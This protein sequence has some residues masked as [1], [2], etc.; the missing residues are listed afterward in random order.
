MPNKFCCI[1]WPFFSFF[2][3]ALLDYFKLYLKNDFCRFLFK[4]YFY[5]F[6]LY[7]LYGRNLL[8]EEYVSF[9]LTLLL[10]HTKNR[11]FLWNT[12]EFI[13]LLPLGM[14]ENSPTSR[15]HVQFS[16]VGIAWAHLWSVPLLSHSYPS[17]CCFSYRYNLFGHKMHIQ[18]L[19]DLFATSC[20]YIMLGSYGRVKLAVVWTTLE[21]TI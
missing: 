20:L 12:T 19:F 9:Y 15:L 21:V 7:E 10:Q 6:F 17:T 18:S 2:N 13:F 4:C 11:D 16:S 1:A 3:V 14:L 5:H 8:Y